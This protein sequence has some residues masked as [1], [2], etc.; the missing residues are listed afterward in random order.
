MTASRLDAVLLALIAIACIVAGLATIAQALP[1]RDYL[2]DSTG[3]RQ[4]YTHTVYIRNP[5]RWEYWCECP[6]GAR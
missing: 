4:G 6:R 2:A 5:L 3:C 1:C